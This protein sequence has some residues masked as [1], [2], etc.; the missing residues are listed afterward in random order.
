M[1]YEELK[2]YAYLN[3]NLM[4]QEIKSIVGS[5]A[6]RAVGSAYLYYCQSIT[7]NV[8]MINPHLS[9]E[10]AGNVMDHAKSAMDRI[11]FRF[12]QNVRQFIIDQQPPELSS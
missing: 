5:E 7:R 4:C 2:N 10:Q 6:S 3:M 9:E 8:R 1:A 12:I 11:S